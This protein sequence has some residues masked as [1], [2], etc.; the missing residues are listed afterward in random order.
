M[1]EAGGTGRPSPE[2]NH[3]QK[4]RVKELYVRLRGVAA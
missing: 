3:E 2:S 1:G 4:L